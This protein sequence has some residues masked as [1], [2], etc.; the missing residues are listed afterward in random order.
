[1]CVPRCIN[2]CG[3]WWGEGLEERRKLSPPPPFPPHSFSSPFTSSIHF[4]PPFPP[5]LLP[6]PIT[7]GWFTI[8]CVKFLK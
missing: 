7:F 8:H 4:C 5:P 6:L 2:A 3:F 1:M